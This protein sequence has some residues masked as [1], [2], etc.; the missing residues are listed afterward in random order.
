MSMPTP[1]G[2]YECTTLQDCQRTME[3]V[4]D[5]KAKVLADIMYDVCNPNHEPLCINNRRNLMFAYQDVL[6]M[7]NQ[8]I[9]YIQCV[10]YKE[11]NHV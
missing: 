10:P 7:V 2:G 9:A 1:I 5:R 4:S 3:I 6:D 11:A 8:R